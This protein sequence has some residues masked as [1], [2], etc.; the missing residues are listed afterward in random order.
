MAWMRPIS[1]VDL[2]NA[3]EDEENLLD[4]SE[5]TFAVSPLVYPL[6]VSMAIR[7]DFPH[8]GSGKFKMKWGTSADPTHPQWYNGDTSN[9][10]SPIVNAG[11]I[12]PTTERVAGY[13]YAVYLEAACG[14]P[15]ADICN[16]FHSIGD[17]FFGLAGTISGVFIIGDY[18]A[19]PF[20]SLAETFHS[21]GDTCCAASAALQE[22][23]DLLEGGITW[24]EISAMILE[25][26]PGLAPLITDPLG[27]ITEIVS[28]LI[29]DLP[30]WLDDPLAWLIATLQEH[31]PLLYYLVVDPKDQVLYLIGQAF[32]LTPYEAQSAEFIVKALFERYFPELYR[33]WLKLDKG[34]WTWLL[35]LYE[36][37]FNNIAK[38]VLRLA[39]FTILYAWEGV[40]P[41][42]PEMVELWLKGTVTEAKSPALAGA[43]VTVVGTSLSTV[44][45]ANGRYEIRGDAPKADSYSLL[46]TKPNY[47][48]TV[49]AGIA[50]HV[51]EPVTIDIGMEY[52]VTPPG[53][54]PAPRLQRL[55]EVY[56]ST[57]EKVVWTR[58]VLE[59]RRGL[60]TEA[61]W[62]AQ[63]DEL[64]AWM[65]EAC[66]DI[67]V[68]QMELVLYFGAAGVPDEYAALMEFRC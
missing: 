40:M 57:T 47:R 33:L 20:V 63:L 14:G 46:V 66:N 7:L 65:R 32:D 56:Q 6:A 48:D 36:E 28:D 61:F 67:R 18:L 52:I 21:L 24:D 38:T 5:E 64:L 43:T 59:T 55:I 68:G 23:L 54:N 29:P 26:W 62:Q 16:V 10:G 11:I 13:I 4:E 35:A 41:A 3:W 39:E 31:F 60:P 2:E 50:A 27:Y 1:Y 25:H 49:I 34:L 8:P 45:D 53:Q 15:L 51:R 30:D 17:F 44:T 9:P 42:R 37:F 19:G 22:I 12:N 58:Q